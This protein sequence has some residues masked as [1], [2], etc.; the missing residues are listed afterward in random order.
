MK[1]KKLILAFAGCTLSFNA[2]AGLGTSKLTFIRMFENDYVVFAQTTQPTG[3]C[4]NFGA[5]FKFDPK[6]SDG[7]TF[8]AMLMTAKA[9]GTAVSVWYTDSPTPG[10]NESNGCSSDN[11][12]KVTGVAI[13]AQ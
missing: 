8:L 11:L 5:Y 2:F 3:T 12:S 1:M 13:E 4:S 6:T 9:T 7:K 10:T